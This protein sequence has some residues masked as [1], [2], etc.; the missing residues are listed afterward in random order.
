M[1]IR[2]YEKLVSIYEYVEQQHGFNFPF[3]LA[4]DTVGGDDPSQSICGLI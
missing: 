2:N 4:M 1:V 3:Q